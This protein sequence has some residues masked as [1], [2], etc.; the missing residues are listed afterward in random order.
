MSS[1]V[2][3]IPVNQQLNQCGDEFL[4]ERDFEMVCDVDSHDEYVIATIDRKPDCYIKKSD[5]LALVAV[6]RIKAPWE[7]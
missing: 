6:M 3:T 7:E 4:N 5:L 1:I 2:I